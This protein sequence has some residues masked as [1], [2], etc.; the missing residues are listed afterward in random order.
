M[1]K[2]LFFDSIEYLDE[3]FFSLSV[4]ILDGNFGNRS[5]SDLISPG[6][7]IINSEGR[8]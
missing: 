1:D 3:G 4:A 6:L 8:L 2:S 7:F 5:H